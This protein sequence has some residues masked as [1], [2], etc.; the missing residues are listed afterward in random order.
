MFVCDV[1]F[2]NNVL[3]NRLR[4]YSYSQDIY[5][6]GR[7]DKPLTSPPFEASVVF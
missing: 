5:S 1:G 6:L 4:Q 2:H 7:E 3:V